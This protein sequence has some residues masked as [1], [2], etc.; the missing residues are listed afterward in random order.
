VKPSAS[1]AYIAPRLS[2][3]MVCCSSRSPKVIRR[4]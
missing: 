2:P 3:L 1:N 4:A